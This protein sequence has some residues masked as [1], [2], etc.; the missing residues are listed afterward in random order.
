M[1]ET[2]GRNVDVIDRTNVLATFQSNAANI[3]STP[4]NPNLTDTRI[5]QREL[6]QS[7]LSQLGMLELDLPQDTSLETN[8]LKLL[9]N[10]ELLNGVS[11]TGQ[12]RLSR[13]AHAREVNKNDSLT[14]TGE[15]GALFIARQKV[16]LQA[17]PSQEL[18]A[19]RFAREPGSSLGEFG[20]VVGQQLMNV[21]ATGQATFIVI[22]QG[23]HSLL[24]IDDRIIIIQNTLTAAGLYLASINDTALTSSGIKSYTILSPESLGTSDEALTSEGLIRPRQI[25]QEISFSQGSEIPLEQGSFIFLT[26]GT[27]KVGMLAPN[28]GEMTKSVFICSGNT[29]GE[30]V[31]TGSEATGIIQSHANTSIK[32]IGLDTDKV[33]SRLNQLL[34][35]TSKFNKDKQLTDEEMLVFE[36]LTKALL[37]TQ[38]QTEALIRRLLLKI[39]FGNK[40]LYQQS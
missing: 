10:A 20:W 26:S 9:Q 33:Q 19:K 36:N 35:L 5:K 34:A 18:K 7:C 38:R 3:E 2:N 8:D 23:A 31:A 24:P 16:A 13:V 22:P 25:T 30:L 11:S 28:S 4:P 32:R 14:N 29:L 27:V 15:E 17:S 37:A 21:I 40:K 6:I 39:D 1:T 12:D